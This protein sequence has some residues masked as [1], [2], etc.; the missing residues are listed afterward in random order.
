MTGEDAGREQDAEMWG[1]PPFV[2][3]DD[4]KRRWDLAAGI[5]EEIFEAPDDPA[6]AWM[7]TRALYRSSIPTG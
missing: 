3:T 6:A 1:Y 4:E 5:A 2:V 7:A